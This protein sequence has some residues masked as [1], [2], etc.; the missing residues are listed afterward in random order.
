MPVRVC[1]GDRDPT[2]T[3][4]ESADIYRALPAGELAVLPATPHELDRVAPARL[5]AL[6]T[7]FLPDE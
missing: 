3:L 2:T 4:A 7:D 6:I 5:L 1:L